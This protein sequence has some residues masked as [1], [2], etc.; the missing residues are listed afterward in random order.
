M[1][2]HTYHREPAR[3]AELNKGER[4]EYKSGVFNYVGDRKFETPRADFINGKIDYEG[5]RF[6]DIGCNT[7]FFIFNALDRGAIYAEGYE[8]DVDSFSQIQSYI[9]LAKEEIIVKNEYFSF[10]DLEMNFDIAHLLN[11]VHHFGDD[12]GS[13][14]CFLD[15]AKDEMLR[16]I[17]SMAGYCRF[18]VFQMGFNWQGKVDK[19]LFNRGS[20]QELID[21]I[22][23]GTKNS[24]MI[25]AIGI[26]ENCDNCIRYKDLNKKNVKRTDSL[27]EFLNRPL[28]IMQSL[29]K[30]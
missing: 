16:E 26:A 14:E 25:K 18:L 6:L 23:S 4:L 21:F 13:N 7:G 12:Y 11:V 9:N 10:E 28:F 19:P 8:G 1:K 29:K 15:G 24:W 27:G 3:F 30:E 5:C 22:S 17:N 2:H 20:K